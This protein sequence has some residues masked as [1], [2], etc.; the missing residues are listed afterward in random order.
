MR[1]LRGTAYDVCG[2][3]EER[4]MERALILE[5]EN[6]IAQIL[7]RLNADNIDI[8]IKVVAEYLEIRGYGPVK[9]AAATTARE[10]IQAHLALL[11]Q[12]E[13]LAA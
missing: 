9:I 8:A 5:F 4:K 13:K 11:L 6:Q 10:N 7:P 12:G 1:S 3:T 2:K